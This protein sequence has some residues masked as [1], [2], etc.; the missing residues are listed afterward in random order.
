MGKLHELLA[1]ESS[2]TGN[3]NRDTAE[4]VK[5]FNKPDMFSRIVTKREH[6]SEDDARLNTIEVKEIT[7][8]VKD[9]LKWYSNS[10]TAFFDLILQKDKTN[11]K[12][13]ADIVVNGEVLAKDVPATTILMLESK[14]QELRKVFDTIPT[15]PAGIR[16][17]YNEND[18]LYTNK[19]PMITFSTKKTTKPVVLYEATKEHPAQVKEVSEDIPVSK[20]IKETAVGMLTS[21]E[22]ANI[23]TR[24]DDLL[25]ACKVAR[26]RANTVD[27]ST[28]KFGAAIMSFL[29]KDLK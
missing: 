16:W 13:T 4:T 18:G 6:F 1:V 3:F 9:R 28:D 7:T 21:L 15:L 29:Y 23:L 24:F 19:D 27:A 12:A 22:K 10:V 26:Q 17:E 2:I 8:S 20:I 11:Q 14:L 25:Q 5:V